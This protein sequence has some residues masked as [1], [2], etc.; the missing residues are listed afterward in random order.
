MSTTGMSTKIV[1]PSISVMI[2]TG[3]EP[4]ANIQYPIGQ[5]IRR[6]KTPHTIQESKGIAASKVLA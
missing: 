2:T 5:E 6:K 1:F 3:E 4:R